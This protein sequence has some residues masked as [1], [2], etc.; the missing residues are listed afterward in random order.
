MS[1]KDIQR[2]RQGLLSNV[3]D[4]RRA[5]SRAL[6]EL[7]TSQHPKFIHLCHLLLDDPEPRVRSEILWHLM[8]FGDRDDTFA[9]SRAITALTVPVLRGR[10]VMALGTIGTEAIVPV[11]SQLAASREVCALVAF[12]HQARTEDER[13]YA[14]RLGREWLLSAEY[15]LR[16]EA[17]RALKILSSA[18]AEEELLVTAYRQY[19]DELVAWALGGASARMLPVLYELRARWPEGCAEYKDVSHAIRRMELR[20]AH[21]EATE[22]NFGSRARREYL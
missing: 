1:P 4:E 11:L 12:A 6:A 2:I 5:A 9:E 22:L 7:A 14:L 16:D 3:V 21:G 10:A 19:G 8:R 15:R 18:E 17:L 13:A 20:I